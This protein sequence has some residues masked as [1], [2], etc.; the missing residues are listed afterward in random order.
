MLL[1]IISLHV[2]FYG[3]ELNMQ[4]YKKDYFLKISR[5]KK[6]RLLTG[7]KKL[8]SY[9]CHLTEEGE[10]IRHNNLHSLDIS[11]VSMSYIRYTSS[12]LMTSFV[13]SPNKALLECLPI[14]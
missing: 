7:S 4:S 6:F 5:K 8:S 9:E 13:N 3:K 11:Y 10:I 14:S 1:L 2:G 12:Y